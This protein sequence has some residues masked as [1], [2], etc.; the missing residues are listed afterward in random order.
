MRASKPGDQ[1][2]RHGNLAVGE[3]LDQHRR[4]QRIVGRGD[5]HARPSPPCGLPD[6]AAAA[7]SRAAGSRRSAA[8]ARLRRRR[9]CADETARP[10]PRACRPAPR[11]PPPPPRP[12]PPA[13]GTAARVSDARA[14]HRARPARR[15]KPAPDAI[16]PAPGGPSS[17]I[18]PLRPVRSRRVERRQRQRVGGRNE[19][20]LAPQRR[21]RGQ[22]E[23]QLRGHSAAL[24]RA[25]ANRRAPAP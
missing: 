21:A 10:R 17:S 16:L 9:G 18:R 12:P 25:R 2:G 14:D 20:I 11:H 23:G 4:Q 15:P 24:V 22:I 5:L 1:R 3:Q 13:P 19:E 6:R 7:P 8:A